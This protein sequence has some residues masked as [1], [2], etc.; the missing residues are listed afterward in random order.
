MLEIPS[1]NWKWASSGELVKLLTRRRYYMQSFLEPVSRNLSPNEVLRKDTKGERANPQMISPKKQR[2]RI[3]YSLHKRYQRE[4]VLFPSEPDWCCLSMQRLRKALGKTFEKHSVM[5]L[6]CARTHAQRHSRVP[7][8]IWQIIMEY[9]LYFDLAE[10]RHAGLHNNPCRAP[11]AELHRR[12]RGKDASKL[13]VA[14]RSCVTHEVQVWHAYRLPGPPGMHLERQLC[15]ARQARADEDW[16][17]FETPKYRAAVQQAENRKRKINEGWVFFERFVKMLHETVKTLTDHPVSC[18]FHLHEAEV[19]IKITLSDAPPFVFATVTHKSL[20]LKNR[21]HRQREVQIV[22]DSILNGTAPCVAGMI[23]F[24]SD[25]CSGFVSTY[26]DWAIGPYNRRVLVVE[27]RKW[28]YQW[29]WKS[30][31]K[32]IFIDLPV[33]AG[34][35]VMCRVLVV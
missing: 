21:R 34:K 16:V 18:S 32:R 4:M 10:S 23:K 26:S 28:R 5:A 20:V 17:W 12:W 3:V 25:Y 7:A 15:T 30:L 19:V 6:L 29:W 27:K 33:R 11:H 1:L 14:Q 35:T 13:A 9:L 31:D 24:V 8:I 2:D 22:Y